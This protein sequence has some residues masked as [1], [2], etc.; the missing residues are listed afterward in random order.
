MAEDKEQQLKDNVDINI[1]DKNDLKEWSEF[2]GVEEGS[3]WA[4]IKFV[5]A[6]SQKVKNF[7]VH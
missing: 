4:A 6:S 7:L 1:D 2:F 5:G 3:L